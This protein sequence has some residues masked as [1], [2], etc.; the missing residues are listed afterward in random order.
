MFECKL[1]DPVFFKKFFE[2]LKPIFPDGTLQAKEDGIMISMIE[3]T[4]TMAISTF[5]PKEM[6]EKYNCDQATDISIYFDDFLKA[7]TRLG[8]KTTCKLTLDEVKNN[9]VVKLE[10]KLNKKFIISLRDQTLSESIDPSETPVADISFNIDGDLFIEALKDAKA[11][12][13]VQGDVVLKTD[14]LGV[15]H[16]SS[17][18]THGEMAIE[19]DY[20][21]VED[22]KKEVESAFAIDSLLNIM[23]MGTLCDEVLVE[24]RNNAP[25]GISFIFNNFDAPNLGVIR[26]DYLLA[27]LASDDDYEDDDEDIE[28]IFDENDDSK[29]IEGEVEATE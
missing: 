8:K 15:F 14:D 2:A 27:P 1:K 4:R 11:I 26:V 9:L 21:P 12:S 18:G 6:F 29:Q 13:G 10:G 23:K 16:I 19:M 25:I 22:A 5:L 7:F 28:K 3:P 24:M 20:E 17:F